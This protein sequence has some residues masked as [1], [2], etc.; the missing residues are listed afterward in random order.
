M[1]NH[2]GLHLLAD[3]YD[4]N[5]AVI[6]NSEKVR[7]LMLEAARRGKATIVT[8]VFHAFNPHGVSGVIVIAESH[9]AIHTWPEHGVAAV[10]VFSCSEKMDTAAILNFLKQAFEARN[11]SVQDQARGTLPAS[12]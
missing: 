11:M 12:H 7:A 10:D 8:D 4:C 9:L 2:L 1:K 6:G 5:P 3:F